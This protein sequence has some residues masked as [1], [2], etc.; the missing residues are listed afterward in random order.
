MCGVVCVSVC[1]YWWGSEWSQQAWH[2]R[3]GRWSNGWRRND[4]QY[5]P[6]SDVVHAAVTAFLRQSSGASHGVDGVCAGPY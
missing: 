6:V 5:G 1:R 2:G 3:N 4:K